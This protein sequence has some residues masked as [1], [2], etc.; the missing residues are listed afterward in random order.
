M[1]NIIVSCNRVLEINF[2]NDVFQFKVEKC[3]GNEMNMKICMI[4]KLK[5]Y[6]Y[7][8]KS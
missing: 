7:E 2:D 3:I 8:K 4:I 1:Q 5:C 6:S